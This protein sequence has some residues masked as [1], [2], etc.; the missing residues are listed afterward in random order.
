V[1]DIIWRA[2]GVLAAVST[3]ALWA[4]F[5][6]RNPYAPTPEDR[7]LLLGWL[8]MLAAGVSVAVAAYGAHLGMYLLFFASFFPMGLMS[9]MGPGVFRAIGWMNLAY[10]ASAVLL[11]R[12]LLTAKRKGSGSA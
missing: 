12:S 2:T 7:W 1:R 3:L 5:L 8:M 11:H 4:A 10:L 9:L 6:Y